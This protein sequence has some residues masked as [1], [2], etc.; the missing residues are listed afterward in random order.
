MQGEL[1]LAGKKY[2]SILD[3]YPNNQQAIDGLTA[4]HQAKEKTPPGNPGPTQEQVNELIAFC[5]QG[6]FQEAVVRG[7]MLASQFPNVPFIP[8]LLGAANFNLGRLEQAVAGFRK[9]LQIKPDFAEAHNNL[10]NALNALGKPEEAMASFR[11]ALQIKPDF[12]EV[13]NNLANVL[14]ALGRHEEAVVSSNKALQIRPDIAG[15]HNNLGIALNELGK[16]QQAIAAYLEALNINPGF[17][18]VH[19]NLGNALYAVGQPEEAVASYKKAL[20]IKPDFAE[21]LNNLGNVLSSLGHFEEASAV[22]IKALQVRP[23]FAV[24]HRNLS[25]AKKYQVG[26]SQLE[27]MLR[28]VERHDLPD[29]DRMHLS[30]AL[31]KAF[32]DLGDPDNAFSYLAKAN[33]LRK[34]ELRYD[35]SSDQAFF[36]K[37]KSVFSGELPVPDVSGSVKSRQPVF[38]LGMPRSGTSLV[39][40]ILAS[41]S[42][43]HGAGELRLLDQSVS[44]IEWQSGQISA[45]QLQSVRDS[46]LSGLEKLAVSESYVTDKMPL[47]FQ[48]IGFIVAA[49]PE[50]KIIHVKRDARATCWSCFK[51]YF[52]EKGNGFAYDLHDVAEYFRMYTDLMA[53]WHEKYPGRIYDLSYEALTENQEEESRNLLEYVGLDWEDQCLSFHENRRAVR[54]ASA[55]QVRQKMYQGSSEEWRRY[56]T[57]LEPLVELLKGF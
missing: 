35:I 42:G 25:T 29:N 37:I 13:H 23:D 47:N 30:F 12:A 24:A 26:D 20:Q 31:G 18:E 10:G 8:N 3:K 17:A 38:I 44:T 9:A 56:E 28:L 54:T 55:V 16:H 21:A 6:Q 33:S 45:H 32:E 36:A 1:D 5:N 51:N 27:Q 48:R 7:E 15:I 14:N 34:Q 39:E 4:I 19:A 52:S 43:V 49:L 40:Q 50:A 41:H 2:Q 57:H 53:F 46:Y 11:Q 22:C